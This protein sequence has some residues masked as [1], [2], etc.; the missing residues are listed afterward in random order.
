VIRMFRMPRPTPY[1]RAGHG[2]PLL[3]LHPF[4][5]SHDVWADAMP[6]LS[7]QYD[8]VAMTLPGH[9]GGPPLRRRDVS[10]KGFADGIEE[11]LDELGWE[12]CHIVGNSIGGWLALELARRGRARS[13]TAIAP[14]GGWARWSASQFI[15]GAKFIAMAPMALVGRV[16]G[17][18]GSHLAVMRSLFLR[19]VSHDIAAVPR[20]RADNYLRA[21]SHCSS[22][23]AY[24]WADLRDGGVQGLADVAVPVQILLCAEDWLLPPKRYARLFT[25][26]LPG[27]SVVMVPGVGHVPTLENPGPVADLIR[28]HIEALPSTETA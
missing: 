20:E 7:D 28:A 9:W 12:T 18:L 3:L 6:L 14:A 15:I 19:V 23:L 26:G 8:V 17:D 21:A 4:L 16:T 22:F 2:E 11:F 10:I 13:V 5:L 1:N 24:M 27:A 25:D